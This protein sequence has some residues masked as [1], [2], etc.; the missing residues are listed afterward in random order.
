MLVGRPDKAL[1]G[2][3]DGVRMAINNAVPPW[4][5]TPRVTILLA[6]ADLPKRGT[7]STWRSRS[8]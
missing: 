1:H 5:A 8:R 7:H 2:A 3:H 6:P 4:P